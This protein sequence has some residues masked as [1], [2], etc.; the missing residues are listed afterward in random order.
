MSVVVDSSELRDFAVD[1]RRL[2]ASLSRH[3]L[4]VVHRGAVRVKESMRRDLQASSNAG[5][6]YV[7]RTVN[8]DVVE[9]AGGVAAEIG[10]TK[11]D[12][13]LANIAYFGSYKGGGTVRDPVKALE[14]EAP[15]FEKAIL[16]VVEQLW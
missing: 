9:G 15:K 10:P 2:P 8:Y 11:P 1:V 6:Q 12:G 16:D 5:F 13:A 14:D 3:L 7:A 4:P